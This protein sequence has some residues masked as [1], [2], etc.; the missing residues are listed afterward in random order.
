MIKGSS[1]LIP[2]NVFKVR[3]EIVGRIPLQYNFI[4]SK[5]SLMILKGEDQSPNIYEAG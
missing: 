2:A 1:I 5:E 3:S 4:I